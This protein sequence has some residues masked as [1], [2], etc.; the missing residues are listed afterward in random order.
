MSVRVEESGMM[1]GEYDEERV[2]LIEKSD[3]YKDKLMPNGVKICEFILRRD[4]ALFF[5][6]A[7]SSCPNRFAAET[8]REKKEKYE[9]YVD[10]IVLKMRHSLTL[11]AAVLLRRYG[12]EGVPELL[13]RPDLS[14]LRIVLMLVVKDAEK[15]WL[16]EL[17]DVFRLKLRHEMRIWNNAGFYVV[18]ERMARAKGLV[19]ES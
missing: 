12:A 7:K 5:V 19:V 18:N 16:G 11:Y 14:G 2:F 6:E 8:S 3:Q 4:D 10:D 13:R 1:F 9:A 15:A 17:Q